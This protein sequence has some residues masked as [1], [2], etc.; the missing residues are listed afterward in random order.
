MYGAIIGDIVGSRFEFSN[1]KTKD[2]EL[3][4]PGCSHTDDT[5]MTLAVAQGLLRCRTAGTNFKKELVQSMKELGRAYPWAGYGSRFKRWL[6]SD[7]SKPYK[8]YGNGSAM[9]ASPCGWVASSRKEAIDLG[10]DSAAVTHNHPD[11]LDGG[12][13]AS[14]LVW[15]ARNG[16]SK[17]DIRIRIGQVYNVDF[18][19]EEIR[20]TYS[21]S[22]TCMGSVPQ[23]VVAFLESESFEDAIRNAVSIGGD[24][25]TIACMTGAIA[26]AYYGM[27]QH[28]KEQAMGILDNYCCNIV[29]AFR[30]FC[31]TK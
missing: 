12:V 3:F 8:S 22:E 26:E 17:Q 4:H 16:G 20:P 25:D 29:L 28:F 13:M 23:A 19:L 11:G 18:T 15:I 10:Y 24:S 27:P 5:V 31:H 6:C 7:R 30:D 1:I 21:F 2:F 14:E 9:R